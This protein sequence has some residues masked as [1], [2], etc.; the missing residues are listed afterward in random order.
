MTDQYRIFGAELSPFSV[1]IRSYFRY[2]QIPH[3]WIVRNAASADEYQKFAKIPI[4]PLVV[5][6][7]EE[8]LQDSTPIIEAIEQRFPGPTI[9]PEDPICQFISTMIEEFG[10]EWGNKWFFHLR[11]ARDEDCTSA[12]GR[13]AALN[14][15]DADDAT[16]ATIRDQIVEHMKGRVFFVGSNEQ[17][18]PQIEQSFKDGIKLLDTHF[19]KHPYLFGGKPAFG[20]FGLWGQLYCAW[21]DP[22]AGAL[23]EATAPH[24]LDWIHRMLW[25]TDSGDY[26]NWD[27]LAPTLMPFVKDQIGDLFAPW[28]VA[29]TLA[30]AAGEDEFT[31]DL[32]GQSFSQ[33][34]QKYHV[35]SLAV[36]REKYATAS[37]NAE[38]YGVLD[39]AGC[40]TFLES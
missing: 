25:P 23:I 37:G 11:W 1:K 7:E 29:N 9:H 39:A 32:K 8:S 13:I 28:T 14:T 17:T 26:E 5:T 40:L 30:M 20:D 19:S 12:G 16:R 34:P 2:K 35:K 31:V 22:T 36:L 21:T 27:A 6:P 4:I 18:A 24:L 3:Q 38:L 15:P 33:K 10:D